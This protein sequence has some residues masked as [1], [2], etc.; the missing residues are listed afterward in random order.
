MKHRVERREHLASRQWTKRE[1]AI[2]WRGLT[3]RFAIAIE[4]ALGM[5]F[6]ALLAW[7]IVWRAR[8]SAPHDLWILSPI[9]GLMAIGFA[10][11]LVAVVVAPL[12]A[13]AQTYKPIYQIDGFVRYRG[14]DDYSELDASGYVA[15]L[16]EDRTL[17]CEWES[18]GRKPLP[19]TTIAAMVEFSEFGGIHKIDGVSTGLLPDGDLPPLAIGIA[20]R[21]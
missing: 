6:F 4:P 11:Y 20:P 2:V 13:Y 15:A 21:R 19:N 1:R 16:F 18:F 17:C 9:F 5:V 8:V 3:G 10:I 7:G 12:V 14:P